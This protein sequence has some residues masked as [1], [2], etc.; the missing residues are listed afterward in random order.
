MV[1]SKD[2]IILFFSAKSTIAIIST[3]VK[4][5]FRAKIVHFTENHLTL[6]WCMFVCILQQWYTSTMTLIGTWL[7]D[8][9]DLQLHVY[10]LKVLIRIVKVRITCYYKLSKKSKE[11]C[12]WLIFPSL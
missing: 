6:Q 7:T 5:L 11:I 3:E 8:R 9:V 1:H 10:Q 2:E 4:L 12:V